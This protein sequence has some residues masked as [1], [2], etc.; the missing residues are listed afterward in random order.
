MGDGGGPKGR[1]RDGAFVIDLMP[2]LPVQPYLLE[3]E[4]LLRARTQSRNKDLVRF[5]CS[6][7]LLKP[8]QTAMFVFK[9][10]S[11]DVYAEY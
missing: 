2:V 3:A 9:H 1:H 4:R 10:E 5:F 6:E 7:Q 8:A 11:L